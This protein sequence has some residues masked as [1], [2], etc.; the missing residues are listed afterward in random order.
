M[1]P[2]RVFRS[3]P[4]TARHLTRS[5]SFFLSPRCSTWTS[6]AF[7]FTSVL[8]RAIRTPTATPFSLRGKSSTKRK[9]WVST[10]TSWISAVVSPVRS[11]PTATSPKRHPTLIAFE[12]LS[13]KFSPTTERLKVCKSSTSPVATS[14]KLRSRWR[15]SYTVRAKGRT[16]QVSVTWIT[17]SPTAC[18]ARSTA[19]SMT[20]S[21]C[22][23][24]SCNRTRLPRSLE[25]ITISTRLRFLPPCTGRPA[26]RS[27][28]SCET[29]LCR[30]C[31]TVT[32][33]CSQMPELTP[34]L[35]RAISTVSCARNIFAST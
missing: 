33:S 1:I 12:T 27:I 26:I 31:P 15:A 22:R 11:T 14:R 9:R 35:V 18:T 8:P 29:F 10:C 2:W 24:T 3:E 16:M 34:W 17:T 30:S 20:V 21:T 7:R 28:A 25:S 13:M 19:S 32:G 23:R 6:P 4:S 5:Q